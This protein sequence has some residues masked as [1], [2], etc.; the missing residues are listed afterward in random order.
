M[1]RVRFRLEQYKDE[2]MWLKI[3]SKAEFVIG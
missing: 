2:M 1:R 3:T